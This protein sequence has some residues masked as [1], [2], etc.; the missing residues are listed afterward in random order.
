MFSSGLTADEASIHIIPDR[1]QFFDYDSLTVRCE[2]GWVVKRYTL[3]EQTTECGNTWGKRNNI[4]CNITSLR[5]KD[6]GEYWCESGPA[7]QSIAINITVHGGHVILESP[8][9]PVT[10]G[11]S[12][13]LSCRYKTPPSDLTADFY[14]DGSFIRTEITGN[15]TIPVVNKSDEGL[16][17][18]R[19]P[20]L[21]ESPESSVKVTPCGDS[22]D[23]WTSSLLLISLSVTGLFMSFVIVLVGF[24]Y[25]KRTIDVPSESSVFNDVTYA[26]IMKPDQVSRTTRVR[27][28]R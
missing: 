14:K 24:C 21:G 12:V 15:M 8:A 26:Q 17:S 20:G 13:T 11:H 10:E 27:Q 4:N 2:V 18:C 6:S 23:N 9:L 16:Y 19:H 22:H 3:K 1:L 5:P 7:K 25:C 28:N